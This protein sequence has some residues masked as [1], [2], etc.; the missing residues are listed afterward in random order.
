MHLRC[1]AKVNLSLSVGPPRPS[2]GYHPIASWMV[3][4]SL[5]DDLMLERGEGESHFNV[6]WAAD[7]PRPSPIDWPIEKDL[8][9]KAH[10]T[11]QEHLGRELPVRATLRKRTP[12]GG[13][14]GGGSSDAAAMLKG[15]NELF[16]LALPTEVLAS[17]AAKLGSDVP[18]FLGAPSAVVRGLGEI[19]E[20]APLDQPLY[21]TLILPDLH[22]NTAAVYRMFDLLRPD[23]ALREITAASRAQGVLINDLAEAAFTVE[24]RLRE[25]RDRCAWAAGKGVHVTGSGAAMFILQPDAAAAARTAT[26]LRQQCDVTAIPASS[27]D[28]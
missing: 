15:L 8:I 7:A 9:Y 27:L 18:F 19:V 23:A 26:R 21:L 4:I 17:L 12:T 16:S 3:A 1:P 22:C 2:D 14:L 25:L 10:R 24:P 28:L 6:Q 11:V 13:G 5:H 20:P